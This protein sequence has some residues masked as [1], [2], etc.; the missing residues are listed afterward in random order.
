MT[1][2]L[3]TDLPVAVAVPAAAALAALAIAYWRRLDA[4]E[5]PEPRRRI[6]RFSLLLC[7]VLLPALVWSSSLVDHR[8]D[9]A[10]YVGGWLAC[11]A[12]LAL[13]VLVAIVDAWLSLALHR[14]EWRRHRESLSRALRRGRGDA[15]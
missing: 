8:A 5:V 13:V 9:P 6:R 4:P 7:L 1:L 12:I 2:L 11:F 3:E 15:A 10:G 14:R